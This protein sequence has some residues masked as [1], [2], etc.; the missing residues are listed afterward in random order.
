[1]PWDCAPRVTAADIFPDRYGS[2]EKYSK[3][4]PPSGLRRRLQPGAYQTWVPTWRASLP[5]ERPKVSAR[6]SFQVQARVASTG[7]AKPIFV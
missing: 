6:A 5:T 4:R 1:M 2:S 3:F 7:Y